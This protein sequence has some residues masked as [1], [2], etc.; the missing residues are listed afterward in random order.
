VEIA[1]HSNPPVCKI[2][3]Y[4]KFIYETAKKTRESKKKQVSNDLKTIKIRLNIG[5]SDFAVKV[6]RVIEF[7]EDGDK[8]KMMILF[9][10]REII[11][12]QR[13]FERLERIAEV[14]QEH[15]RLE[16][17]PKLEGRN[18]IAIIAPISKKG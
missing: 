16:R 10:G 9:K 2:M 17:K 1:P 3:D 14:V 7:L 18:I 5:E 15:G 12:K 6:S 11:Y 4:G 13:G 8:V